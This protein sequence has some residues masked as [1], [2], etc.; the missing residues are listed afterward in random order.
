MTFFETFFKVIN[1]VEFEDEG[2]NIVTFDIYLSALCLISRS[3]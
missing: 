2:G 1:S 3:K